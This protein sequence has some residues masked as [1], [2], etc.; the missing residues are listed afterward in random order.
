ML[1][2]ISLMALEN[3]QEQISEM[4]SKLSYMMRY[5]AKTTSVIVPFRED[6]HYIEA[7]FLP[8]SCARTVILNIAATWILL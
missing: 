3:G 2:T 4:L 1:N 6:L 5:S 7:I 8:C